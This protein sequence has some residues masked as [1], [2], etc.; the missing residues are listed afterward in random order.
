MNDELTELKLDLT[1][2]LVGIYGPE[3]GLKSCGVLVPAILRDFSGMIDK[4]SVG[5]T[6][7]ETYRTEDGRAEISLKTVKKAAGGTV[8]ATV[9][10]L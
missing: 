9:R 6:V 4:A 2:Q 7:A 3:E 10:S 5:D 1:R 8:T